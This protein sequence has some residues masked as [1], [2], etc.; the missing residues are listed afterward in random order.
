MVFF[1][2]QARTGSTRLPNKI[3]R[4]F[5]NGNSILELLIEKL[6]QVD[7]TQIIIAT[8]ENR[9]CDP[10]EDIATKSNVLCY[11]GSENDVLH[12]FI[13]ASQEFNADKIIRICSD[14]PFL[15]LKSLIELVNT[16]QSDLGH[17]YISFN[18][19]GSPSIKT[20][21]GFWGEYTTLS[22]LKKVELITN[23]KLYHEHVTNFIYSNPDRF[24]I[25]WLDVN[26]KIMSHNYIRLTIDTMED[27]NTVKEIYHLICDDKK[28]PTI[29]DVIDFIDRHPEYKERMQKQIIQ[30]SK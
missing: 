8:S 29:E 21:Y 19:G 27:F 13:M 20:H 6:K 11:R 5:F 16:A 4:P 30:N 24:S 18:I 25:K 28:Y 17:D 26:P 22:T 23:E 15:E 9:N 10:I 12:R 3:I 2:V 14:N 7:D 1:I